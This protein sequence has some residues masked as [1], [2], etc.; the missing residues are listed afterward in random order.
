MSRSF[1]SQKR[2][3]IAER[4]IRRVRSGAPRLP[5][6][7]QS[8]PRAGDTH[9]LS[10]AFVR[11]VLLNLPIEYLYGLR[12]VELL[13]RVSTEVGIPY[14]LYRLDEKEI[15]LYSMPMSWTWKEAS[16]DSLEIRK[17]RK[18]YAVAI[19]QNQGITIQ[20]PHE[21]MRAMWFYIEVFAHELGHHHR[22]QYQ[23]RNRRA[24]ISD[25]E[26]IASL[27]SNRFYKRLLRRVRARKA[28]SL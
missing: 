14:A 9:P 3:V 18:W 17:M 6:I 26:L 20:W 5:R 27:H 25:E 1:R 10:K 16:M 28:E 4:R 8:R 21:S 23:G 15:L 13:S 24:S 7:V 2:S 12:K 19:E 11:G 22:N